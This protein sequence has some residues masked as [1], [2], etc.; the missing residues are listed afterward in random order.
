[1]GFF[2]HAFSLSLSVYRRLVVQQLRAVQPE[3]QVSQKAE[4]RH[5]T[6]P[7]EKRNVLDFLRRSKLL[8]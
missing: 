4:Q 5:Q 3:R 7:E 2:S 6:S 1:M 8:Y